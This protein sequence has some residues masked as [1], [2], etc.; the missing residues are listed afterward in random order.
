MLPNTS[1]Q[2]AKTDVSCFKAASGFTFYL[3]FTFFYLFCLP[4][5]RD[6]SPASTKIQKSS[7]SDRLKLRFDPWWRPTTNT[8]GLPPRSPR[9]NSPPPIPHFSP[10]RETSVSVIASKRSKKRISVSCHLWSN[11]YFFVILFIF[12]LVVLNLECFLCCLNPR[13]FSIRS[14]PLWPTIINRIWALFTKKKAK[15]F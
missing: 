1:F 7:T 13:P 10:G 3:P 2:L 14:P 15:V 9:A 6:G 11:I 12:I 5:F 4:F 8:G